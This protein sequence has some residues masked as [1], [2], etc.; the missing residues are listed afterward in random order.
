MRR[1]F[2]FPLLLSMIISPITS[3]AQNK[4]P[5]T[6]DDLITTVRSSDPQVSPDGKRVIFT[7]TTTASD[8]G[9]RNSDIWVVPSD[10]SSAARQLIGGEKSENT[11]RFTPDGKRIAFISTRDGAPQVYVADPE[12]RDVKQVTKIS[13]GVQ[14]PL[15]V[16]PDGK[17]VAFV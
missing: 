6:V 9:R 4:R 17:K 8:S 10:G 3:M 14:A 2:L 13:G 1:T 7:R 11:A 5:M 16:S 15:V 12:G